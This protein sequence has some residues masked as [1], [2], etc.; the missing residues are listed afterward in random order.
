MLVQIQSI[1]V[2]VVTL[3]VADLLQGREELAGRET[4]SR[5]P[6]CGVIMI[7]MKKREKMAFSCQVRIR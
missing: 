7:I 1:S 4:S 2:T 5:Y 6:T 3:K